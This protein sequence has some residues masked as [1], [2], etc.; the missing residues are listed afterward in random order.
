MAAIE[1][2]I[3]GVRVTARPLRSDDLDALVAYWQDSPQSYLASLGVDPAKI[4]TR[5]QT[6]ARF[7][8]ALEP[9]AQASI[10]VAEIDGELVAYTSMRV[11]APG[12]AV[13]HFHTLRRD[14]LVRRAVYDLF[15][16]VTA[17]IAA[18][19]GVARLRF[20]PSIANRGINGYLQ[21]FGLRPRRERLDQPDG[22]ARAGEFNVYEL[23]LGD[24]QE[25]GG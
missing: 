4:G 17:A 23:V 2:T 22:L 24:G 18:Q 14:P 6:R 7:A 16:R 12:A 3:D 1:T 11:T 25:G 8:S 20:E 13:A 10:V 9:G 19:L 15:P 5:E 21:S